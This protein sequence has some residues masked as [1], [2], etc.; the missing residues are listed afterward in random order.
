MVLFIFF[1]SQLAQ[2]NWLR[3]YPMGLGMTPQTNSA[4]VG[5]VQLLGGS[6]KMVIEKIIVFGKFNKSILVIFS[7]TEEAPHQLCITPALFHST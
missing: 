7:R 3:S 4:R 6:R 1:S 5:V 2:V